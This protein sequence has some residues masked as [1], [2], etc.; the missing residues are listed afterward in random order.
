MLVVGLGVLALDRK[1]RNLVVFDQAGGHVVLGAQ[2]VGRAH[3]HIRA[4][5]LEGLGQIGGFGGHMEAEPKSNALEGLLPIEPTPD[6]IQDGHALP[7]PLN[8]QAALLGQP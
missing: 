8:A 6:Q 5:G 7:G 1:A 4:A 2:R 3:K